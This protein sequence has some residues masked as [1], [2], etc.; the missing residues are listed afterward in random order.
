MAADVT[1]RS[2]VHRCDITDEFLVDVVEFANSFFRGIDERY[3]GGGGF[4]DDAAGGRV[5]LAAGFS[6]QR[7][8]KW[9]GSKSVL[10][11]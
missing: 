8:M 7:Q 4:E 5:L 9:A 11:E 1:G 10:I 6:N 2:W 3:V